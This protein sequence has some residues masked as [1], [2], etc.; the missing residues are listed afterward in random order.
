MKLR[1]F[2]VWIANLNPAHGTESGKVR[3]VIVVQTDHLNKN[4]YP[5][6]IVCPLTTRVDNRLQ[7]TRVHLLK[8]EAGLNHDSDVMI[9]Q[10]RTIDNGRLVKRIGK[11]KGEKADWILD[12]LAS[13]L[14]IES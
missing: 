8:G 14:N 2:E 5:S 4:N 13:I 7:L 6:T 9:D 1:Q 12:R 11:L 10:M 3:P